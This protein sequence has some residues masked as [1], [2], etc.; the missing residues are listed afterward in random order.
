MAS[1]SP[2][3]TRHGLI[4]LAVAALAVQ[5]ADAQREVATD[6]PYVHGPAHAVYPARI[7]EFRRSSIYQYDSAGK[8]VSASYNLATP[9]GRLLITIYIYPAAPAS[10][11]ARARLCAE[12]FASANAAIANQHGDAAPSEHGQA[13]AVA[14]VRPELSHRAAYRFRS[15]F[16]DH[17]QEIRSEVHLYCYVGGDWLVKYRVSAP[18]AVEARV[19]VA[20]FIRT[21]PWPG[22]SS[23][24]TVA[25]RQ[26][27]EPALSRSVEAPK[28]SGE[29]S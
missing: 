7:G 20:T 29:T 10:S 24:A 8:D 4:L 6:G 12:E 11:E 15:P 19:P 25:Q 3:G 23:A 17:V 1:T 14:D 28:Q 9:E 27:E 21:G 18:V 16:D 26:S 22:R 5:P 13:L 2:P